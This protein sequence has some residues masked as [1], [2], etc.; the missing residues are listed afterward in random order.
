MTDGYKTS[1]SYQRPNGKISKA[2]YNT[3]PLDDTLLWGISERV[4]RVFRKTPLV[5]IRLPIEGEIAHWEF[6]NWT[7]F[8]STSQKLYKEDSDLTLKEWVQRI[9]SRTGMK[10]EFLLEAL[11]Y[12]KDIDA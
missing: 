12:Y 8:L 10:K 2:M 7:S 4:Q 11:K 9:N 5:E 3:T 1:I 6:D